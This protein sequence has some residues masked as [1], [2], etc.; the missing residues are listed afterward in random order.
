MEMRTMKNY[1][2]YLKAWLTVGGEDGVVGCFVLVI[3]GIA[4]LGMAFLLSSGPEELRHAIKA[5][6]DI[7][8]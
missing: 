4:A 1:T 5:V 2:E 6:V 3:L 7:T 8:R